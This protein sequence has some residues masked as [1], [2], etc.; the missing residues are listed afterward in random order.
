M[1]I[2]NVSG[3]LQGGPVYKLGV[4]GGAGVDTWATADVGRVAARFE[5]GP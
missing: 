3:G 4:R 2:H 5:L 1:G